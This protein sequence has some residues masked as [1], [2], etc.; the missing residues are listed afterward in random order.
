[1]NLAAVQHVL[2][3]RIP[4]VLA[5]Y[6]FGSRASGGERADSDL[7]LAVLVPGYA[8]TLCLWEVSN[9]LADVVG[10]SVD[11]L[12]LRAASTVMQYQVLSTGTRVWAKDS[13]ADFFEVAVLNEKLEFDYARSGLL[14]DIKAR[15]GVYA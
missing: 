10:C 13:Q 1:M 8:D 2:C 11:L 15:G 12:D 9:Q 6:I 4:D 14:G 5:I 7:D 3:S